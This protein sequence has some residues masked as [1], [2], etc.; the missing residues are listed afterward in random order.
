MEKA[1]CQY[2]AYKRTLELSQT[3]Q[4]NPQK[5]LDNAST[6]FQGHKGIHRTGTQSV[7]VRT[8]P[9]RKRKS[10]R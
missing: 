5:K 7:A 3:L 8:S 2:W 9:Q 10:D 1:Y 4:K 6:L